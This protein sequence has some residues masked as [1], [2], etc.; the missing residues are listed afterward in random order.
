MIVNM[1][2]SESKDYTLWA[3]GDSP[4]ISYL[5]MSIMVNRFRAWEHGENKCLSAK[6]NNGVGS[7][8]TQEVE[9]WSVAI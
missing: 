4:V 1:K 9:H 7:Q 6:F 8:Q 2:N 5:Y 3:L